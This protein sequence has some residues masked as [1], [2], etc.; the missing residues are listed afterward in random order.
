MRQRILFSLLVLALA[1]PAQVTMAKG[2]GMGHGG[3]P[4]GGNSAAHISSEGLANSNGPNVA[5]RDAGRDR[6]ED[7]R[8][9]ERTTHEKATSHGKR[10]KR[11]ANRKASITPNVSVPVT[12]A[13]SAR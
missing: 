4:S 9:V 7:R 5:D 13:Q 6:A 1:A 10:T 8:S 11:H 3:A 2:G 12:N